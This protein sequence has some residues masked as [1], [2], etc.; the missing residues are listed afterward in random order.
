M[1]LNKNIAAIL[2]VLLLF[3]STLQAQV[4]RSGLRNNHS[5]T[6]KSVAVIRHGITAQITY[7]VGGVPFAGV[8]FNTSQYFGIGNRFMQQSVLYQIGIQPNKF[9]KD[10]LEDPFVHSVLGTFHCSYLGT[11]DLS[12]LLYGIVLQFATAKDKYV[13]QDVRDRHTHKGEY[14]SNIYLRPE[15]GIAYPFRYS[16]KTKEKLPVTFSLTY[17]YNF[18]L[19]MRRKDDVRG[20]NPEDEIPWTASDHHMITLRFN[21]NL[22]H[23]REFQ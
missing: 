1:K 4:N 20:K 19:F 7:D 21:F 6:G 10:G 15:L 22:A 9:G 17:G 13:L 14:M 2:F 5:K 12:P 3:S 23:Y 8:G 18:K 16:S 11:T